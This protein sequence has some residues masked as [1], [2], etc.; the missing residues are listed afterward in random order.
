MLLIS[1]TPTCHKA[2]VESEN[3]PPSSRGNEVV[4][5]REHNAHFIKGGSIISEVPGLRRHRYISLYL[6]R[7]TQTAQVEAD[8][9]YQRSL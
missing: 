8:P 3:A 4:Y 2:G 6:P 5:V 9:V 1:K 7:L